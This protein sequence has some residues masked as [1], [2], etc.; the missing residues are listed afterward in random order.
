[1]TV[2]GHLVYFYSLCTDSRDAVVV[3]ARNQQI[4]QWMRAHRTGN[5]PKPVGEFERMLGR[6]ESLSRDMPTTALTFVV[7]NRNNEE[8]G[9]RVLLNREWSTYASYEEACRNVHKV[10]EQLRVVMHHMAMCP[11]GV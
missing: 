11:D 10:P 3:Q 8:V 2:S 1:M 7:C 5:F 6:F 9:C 4:L